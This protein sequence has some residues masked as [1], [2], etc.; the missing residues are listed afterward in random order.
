MSEEDFVRVTGWRVTQSVET[1]FSVN[2]YRDEFICYEGVNPHTH[3]NVKFTLNEN[4]SA[5]PYS[6]NLPRYS[7]TTISGETNITNL[8]PIWAHI[9][10]PF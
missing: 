7:K 4:G 2:C 6:G 9:P 5:I 10:D 3:E 1:D 8:V